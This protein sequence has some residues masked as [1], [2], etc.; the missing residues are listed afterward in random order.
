MK[1]N[2]NSISVI[3]IKCVDHEITNR[4]RKAVLS[5]IQTGTDIHDIARLVGTTVHALLDGSKLTM[6]RGEE[7]ALH[8]HYNVSYLWLWTGEGKMFD[9]THDIS[10]LLPSQMIVTRKS[11]Q[12]A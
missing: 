6:S 10:V 12:L 3:Q 1:K 11:K 2:P 8:T 5:L 7:V 4:A 9:S